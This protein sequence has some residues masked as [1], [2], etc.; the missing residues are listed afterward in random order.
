MKDEPHFR[1]G[2]AWRRSA[3][4][5]GSELFDGVARGLVNVTAGYGVT[6]VVVGGIVAAMAVGRVGL[7]DDAL[8]PEL[9]SVQASAYAAGLVPGPV[10]GLEHVSGLESASEDVAAAAAAAVAA[11]GAA[12]VVAGAVSAA[13]SATAAGAGTEVWE[14]GEGAESVAVEVLAGP[15]VRL[16]A[17]LP[18]GFRV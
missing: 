5:A 15:A 16:A 7:V 2:A 13:A 18:S 11:V 6:T 1:F 4:Q 17:L 14:P 10:S 8:V 3:S 12:N 9:E